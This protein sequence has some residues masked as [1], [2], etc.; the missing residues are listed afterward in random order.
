MKKFLPRSIAIGAGVATGTL[1]YTG[2]LA[3]AHEFAWGRAFF[4]GVFCG[5]V[6]AVWPRRKK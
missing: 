6:V 5:L 1:I 4:V 2:F 3:S